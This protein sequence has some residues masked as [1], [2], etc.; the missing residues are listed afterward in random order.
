MRDSGTGERVRE[1]SDHRHSVLRVVFVL[2]TDGFPDG[3]ASTNR[4]RLL[5]AALAEAGAD[6]GILCTQANEPQGSPRNQDVVGRLGAVT[7]EYTTGRTTRARGFLSRR[8]V[9]L[10]GF[11]V[12]MQRLR[13]FSRL[14][15]PLVCY[16]WITPSWNPTYSTA[17]LVALHL[18][19]V[20]CVMELNEPAW[21]FR[22][23]NGRG[24]R[25]FSSLRGMAGV[26]AIST[27]LEE[28]ALRD[29]RLR[30]RTIPLMR[31]PAVSSRELAVESDAGRAGHRRVVLACAPGH[32]GRILF[33]INAMERVWAATDCQLVLAGFD[34]VDPRA[35]WLRSE[36]AYI[37][38]RNKIVLAGHLDAATLRELYATASVLAA[39]LD[40][41]ERSALAFPTKVAEYLMTG[42]PVITSEIGDSGR[43]LRESG[44]AYLAPAGDVD[45]FADLLR[46]VLLDPRGADEVGRAGRAVALRELDATCYGEALAEFMAEVV[47]SY[48]E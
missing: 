25:A 1:G 3:M 9:D 30:G 48:H 34:E 42:R 38:N 27:G 2:R 10:R 19:R 4:V 17:T 40:D 37:R 26:V 24:R 23:G 21:S 15:G 39:P 29:M 20:P 33:L 12:L 16:S 11:V 44:G 6:V 46:E 32:R 5:A 13:A 14:P 28:W 41:N 8:L 22:P 45:A 36:P 31:I 35:A 18:L 7:F 47:H 43:L